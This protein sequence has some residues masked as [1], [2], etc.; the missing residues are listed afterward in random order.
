MPVVFP[1]IPTLS[2]RLVWILENRESTATGR[3]LRNRTGAGKRSSGA[4]ALSLS[5]GLARQHVGQ[6]IL[7]NE[8]RQMNLDTARA[9]AWAAQVSLFWLTTGEGSPDGED[10]PAAPPKNRLVKRAQVGTYGALPGWA[11]NV[12]AALLLDPP[13]RPPMSVLAGADMPIPRGFRPE[14]LTPELVRA[15]C[16]VA[17][18]SLSDPRRGD[19]S[20]TFLSEQAH[21]LAEHAGKPDE[22]KPDRAKQ[23]RKSIPPGG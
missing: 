16:D 19:Y 5:A 23:L 15:V 18:R 13:I 10:I 9:L 14:K 20:D 3:V 6:I 8:T 7:S 17:W 2:G 1:F 12:A 11:I 4:S 21:A 22:G